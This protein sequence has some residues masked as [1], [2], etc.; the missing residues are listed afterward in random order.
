MPAI[1]LKDFRFCELKFYLSIRTAWVRFDKTSEKLNLVLD[2]QKFITL[3][4]F[5]VGEGQP[6]VLYKC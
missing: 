5:S 4:S 3:E 6:D 1:S 2:K